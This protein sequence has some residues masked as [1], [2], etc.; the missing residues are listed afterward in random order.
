M[1][2]PPA[3]GHSPSRRNSALLLQH[4]ERR[5]RPAVRT[6]PDSLRQR[7]P[8]LILGDRPAPLARRMTVTT[9]H[10]DGR[11]ALPDPPLDD[12]VRHRRP[13]LLTP[14][15]LS[16]TPLLIRDPTTGALQVAELH[17]LQEAQ[18]V[19]TGKRSRAVH[20]FD[21]RAPQ[22]SNARSVRSTSVITLRATAEPRGGRTAQAGNRFCG[23]SR[24]PPSSSTGKTCL[25]ERR[26]C[27]GD[28]EPRPRFRRAQPVPDSPPRADTRPSAGR[29]HRDHD[30]GRRREPRRVHPHRLQALERRRRGRRRL[31]HPCRGAD[32]RGPRPRTCPSERT[33]RLPSL[34]GGSTTT[35]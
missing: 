31:Q 1:S 6:R 14:Q 19:E 3:T 17:A 16:F 24:R 5:I 13:G 18:Q 11:T 22:V 26:P 35:G 29:S 9:V 12:P 10:L 34:A 27:P 21:S 32:R 8:R 4:A 23:E 7:S 20:V 30:A 2:W 15:P 25:R 28:Q 33:R